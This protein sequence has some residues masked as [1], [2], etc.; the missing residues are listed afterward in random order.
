MSHQV[1]DFYEKA[2]QNTDILRLENASSAQVVLPKQ[3][4][5]GC[6]NSR[7]QHRYTL[8]WLANSSN[9]TLARAG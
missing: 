8:T 1:A 4:K 3:L 5:H 9:R 7:D 6:L 2:Q